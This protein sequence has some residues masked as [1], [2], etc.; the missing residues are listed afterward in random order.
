MIRFFFVGS[1][2]VVKRCFIGH[3]PGNA[4]S[5]YAAPDVRKGL[6]QIQVWASKGRPGSR[7]V[8]G[9]SGASDTRSPMDSVSPSI[10]LVLAT[11]EQEETAKL[12]TYDFWPRFYRSCRC[13]AKQFR[14]NALR[15]QGA[16]TKKK[17]IPI[18]KSS[19]H[20]NDHPASFAALLRRMVAPPMSNSMDLVRK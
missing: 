18:V 9:S 17:N 11:R 5:A 20:S 16:E 4:I 14:P 15:E 6:A 13:P 8:G 2:S 10:V 1:L 3:F 12:F 7:L 19:C